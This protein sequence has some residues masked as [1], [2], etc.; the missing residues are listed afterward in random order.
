MQSIL[1]CSVLLTFL[2]PVVLRPF[3]S[4]LVYYSILEDQFHAARMRLQLSFELT[5]FLPT[6]LVTDAATQLVSFARELRTSG[7]DIV[8]EE[9][10]AAI[11]GR[12][13][14]SPAIESGFKKQVNIQKFT[15][16]CHGTELDL[17]EGVSPTMLRA[18]QERK[19]F[20][21]VF[22]LSMLG[23]FYAPQHLARMI[24]KSITVRFKTKVADAMACSSQS[25][26]FEWW[27]YR[28]RIEDELRKAIPNYYYR[29]A[30]RS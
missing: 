6:G 21:T 7:S 27:P 12:G 11:F 24:S 4:S 20:A 1:V 29:S 9:D 23:Y 19:Y 15:P 22:T 2:I 16:L 8:V 28:G 30:R 3:S 26:A 5:K 25:S 14:I 17:A 13:R 18:F 10:L